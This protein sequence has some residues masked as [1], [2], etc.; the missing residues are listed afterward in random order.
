M[1][2]L[3]YSYIARLVYRTCS[4]SSDAFAELYASTYKRQY[5]LAYVYLE[6]EQLARE[7]LKTTYSRALKNLASLRDTRLFI[8]WL[9]QI[10]FRVC[11]AIAAR[12]Q[13][14]DAGETVKAPTV[15]VAGRRFSVNRILALPFSE[16]QVIYLHCKKKLS[17]RQIAYLLEMR[18]SEAK[19]YLRRGRARLRVEPVLSGGGENAL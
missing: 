11:C 19:E 9:T 17:L 18:P 6:D 14:I 12:H 7:A 1:S 4:G 16:S 15:Q 13:Q 5:A 10:N 3:D 2:E 8:S